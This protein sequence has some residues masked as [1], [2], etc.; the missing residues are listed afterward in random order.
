M[1]VVRDILVDAQ[2][3]FAIRMAE[4]L[5]DGSE[6]LACAQCK[7]GEGMPRVMEIDAR[8]AGERDQFGETVGHAIRIPGLAV[9]V[10][11]DQVL[12]LVGVAALVPVCG[13]AFLMRFKQRED[14]RFEW[15]T[16]YRRR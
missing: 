10:A 11:A 5:G 1:L 9:R 12:V 14:R 2:R 8:H 13:L 7:A 6:R 3:G 15:G 4:H 16:P